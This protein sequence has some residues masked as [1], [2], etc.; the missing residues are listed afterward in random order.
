MNYEVGVVRAF[1][2]I[3]QIIYWNRL[4]NRVNLPPT[5]FPI[6]DFLAK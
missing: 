3:Y 1:Q 4:L 5:W 6:H 2:S